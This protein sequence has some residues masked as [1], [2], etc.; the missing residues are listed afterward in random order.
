[1]PHNPA[2]T[3]KYLFAGALALLAGCATQSHHTSRPPAP[4]PTT[5]ADV[6]VPEAWVS[7]PVPEDELDS[8]AAWPTED[9]RV[10]LIA[11][12]KS[13][14]R[15]AVY[16]G[17]TGERLHTVGGP[18]QAPG[19]FNRPN[20]IAVFGD[21][22]FV[23]ERDNHRVQ[24]MRLPEF[25]PVAQ[26][27]QDAL[28]V[29]YGLWLDET[30]P[31]QLDLFVTD[32]FMADFRTGKLPPLSEL[33]QR[34]KHFRVEEDGDG[35][36][37]WHLLGSFGAT[38]E[39]GALRMVES[40][41]GDP[42]HDRL[43][44]A[45]EDRR[46]G[47]TLRDYTLSGQYRGLSLPAFDADAEGI[48]LWPCAVDRGYWIAVDQLTPTLFRVFDR[49]SLAPR[50]IFRGEQVGNTDGET[51]YAASTRRFPAGVL[52]ALHN[53]QSLAAFD[54]RDVAHALKLGNDCLP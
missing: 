41:A 23:A 35:S 34:I 44:I 53:D 51:L 21:L 26:I 2:M 8:L 28:K 32:S 18:G 47:S 11:T 6:I 29:P 17:D 9:G 48:A 31:G 25:T 20:G 50:G 7:A 33:D 13:S 12:A 54:L 14:H 15:L 52:F 49:T 19:Q 4:T 37:R 24:V 1:M 43:L 46:V 10:W 16:D 27:G 39:A 5:A 42:L 38:D 30:G 40:I 22:L 45:D 3:R 36:V